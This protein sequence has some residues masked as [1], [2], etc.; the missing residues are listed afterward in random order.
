MLVGAG[1]EE[2]L[3]PLRRIVIAL[4]VR[5]GFGGDHQN[6]RQL[7]TGRHDAKAQFQKCWLIPIRSSFRDQRFGQVCRLEVRV[8]STCSACTRDVICFS[9]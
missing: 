5:E 2:F 1:Y 3:S 9:K 6:G 4:G 8:Q 7:T